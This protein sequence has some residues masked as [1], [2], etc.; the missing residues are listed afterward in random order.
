MVLMTILCILVALGLIAI[1]RWGHLDLEVPWDSDEGSWPLAP[2]EA[3]RRFLWY[4]TIALVS[5]IVAGV[6][7]IG[8][9][10]R[11]AMRLLA[12]TAGETAQGRITEADEVVGR[13]TQDGTIGFILFNGILGGLVFGFL[14]MVIRRWLPQGRWGGIAYGSLLL[15]IG[16]TRIDPLRAE[17]PDFD[18]V[19][20]GWL[21]LA[22]FVAL[23]LAYGMLVSALAGRYSRVLPLITKERRTI[24]R[25]APLLLLAPAFIVIV[26]LTIVGLLSMLFSRTDSL[27]RILGSRR[28]LIVGR[29]V[30]LVLV[31]IAAPGFAVALADIAAR[32]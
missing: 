18:I 3:F 17:N 9:G 4:M 7:M 16:G 12:I 21:A 24:A 22:I 10:G 26:P 30:G 2:R 15:I 1:W 27:D 23:G 11:L 8:A 14:Y 29:V 32:P 25:Y 5:G 31:A 20:P 13:I 6:V 28:T 19:G